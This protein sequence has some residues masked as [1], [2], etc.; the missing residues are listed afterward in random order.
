[1]IAMNTIA[2]TFASRLT[3]S[4][5]VLFAL[6]ASVS[7]QTQDAHFEY[8]R[9]SGNSMLPGLKSGEM[10]VICKSYPFEKLRIGDVVIIESE[11]GF[12]VIHRVVRRHRNGTWITQGDNNPRADRE[13]LSSSNF[14]GLALV[15]ESVARFNKYVASLNPEIAAN[16][17]VALADKSATVER[18]NRT[19][20]S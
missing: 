14:G 3:L 7:A 16:H 9:V 18:L 11:R 2:Q 4:F 10:T 15:D 5:I 13:V 19:R 20:K 1:M 12:S 17:K 8:T 6:V